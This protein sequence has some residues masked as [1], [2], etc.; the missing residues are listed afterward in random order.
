M[1]GAGYLAWKELALSYLLLCRASEMW[2]YGNGLVH[3]ELCLTRGDITFC[4]G[5]TRLFGPDRKRADRVEVLLRVSKADH[6][7][8]GATITRTR[9]RCN[10]TK[11]WGGDDSRTVE[12]LL[13]PFDLH[14]CGGGWQIISR[15]EATR[16]LRVLVGSPGN[17][18]Q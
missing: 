18:P 14:S 7:R 15:S 1:E 10:N 11:Q 4:N 5:P 3:S 13:D 12:I 9:V 16:A 8:V 17:E 6:N 2:A